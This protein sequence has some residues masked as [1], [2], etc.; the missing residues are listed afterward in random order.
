MTIHLS[1]DQER[2]VHDAMRAGL[3]SNEDEVICDALSRMERAL[4]KPARTTA[5]T[6]NRAKPAPS[7]AKNRYPSTNC[8]ARC[9]PAA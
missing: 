8:T 6:S 3:Y 9:W 7:S 1:K 4:P 2:F 5:K